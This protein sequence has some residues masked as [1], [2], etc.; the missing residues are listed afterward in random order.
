V[1]FLERP[2]ASIEPDIAVKRSFAARAANRDLEMEA[3]RDAIYCD[4][5]N[6]TK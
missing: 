6:R 5:A 4:I 3:A 2:D 1:V